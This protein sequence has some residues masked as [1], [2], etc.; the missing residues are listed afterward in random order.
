MLLDIL[1]EVTSICLDL[2]FL[3]LG[4]LCIIILTMGTLVVEAVVSLVI[5]TWIQMF[6]LLVFMSS[7]MWLYIVLLSFVT[8]L[9]LLSN[10]YVVH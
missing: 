7:G 1:A 6:L 8:V 3:R 5:T 4:I 2:I 10:V 9:F